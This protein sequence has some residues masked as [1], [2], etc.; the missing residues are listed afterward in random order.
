MNRSAIVCAVALLFACNSSEAPRSPLVKS[1]ARARRHLVHDAV[2]AAASTHAPS[3]ASDPLGVTA[4]AGRYTG[5]GVTIGVISDSFAHCTSGCTTVAADVAAGNLPGPGNPNGDTTPVVVVQEGT[6]A[7]DTAEGRAMLQIIYGLAPKAKLCFATIGGTQTSFANA[8][9][10]LAS[11]SGTCKANIIVDDIFFD[12]EPFFSDGTVGA[13]VNQAAA[14]GVTYVSSG[15]NLTPAL[16][17]GTFNPVSDTAARAGTFGNLKLSQVPPALTAG[18]F[19]D[20]STTNAQELSFTLTPNGSDAFINFQWDDPFVA[21]RISADYNLLVF[22]AAGNYRA[23]LSGIDKNTS[24]GEPLELVN[25]PLAGGPYQVAISLAAPATA[26][27]ARHLRLIDDDTGPTTAG[28]PAQVFSP[29]IFGHAA[30]A[31]SI[32]V[33]S[34]FHGDLTAPEDFNSYGPFT[35]LFDSAGNRLATAES[36][37]KPEVSGLDGLDT[38]FFPSG[39]GNDSDADGFPNL[40]GDTAS[41]STVAA[42]AALSIQAAGGTATPA[43]VASWL[44]RSASHAGLWAAPDG[45]GYINAVRATTLA[46][47]GNLGSNGTNISITSSPNPSFPGSAVTVTAH[48]GFGVATG[49][50]AAIPAVPTGVVTFFNGLTQVKSAALDSTGTAS[51]QFDLASDATI[52]ATYGGD[53]TNDAASAATPISQVVSSSAATPDAGTT[54]PDA[55]TVADG[56]TA[57]APPPAGKSGCNSN[58]STGP[59]WLMLACA[60]VAAARARRNVRGTS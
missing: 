39:A 33:S 27:T 49:L 30:A 12:D 43:Q 44:T 45:F 24:T 21:A 2:H 51:V 23:D 42:V 22:D 11:T 31:G 37:L 48:V 55:G 56:G 5:A 41:A 52:R 32:A 14:A 46:A 4:L 18:G 26:S 25:L 9:A 10:S 57:T 53:G 60:L 20:F 19:H 34:Y 50:S 17:D 40:F 7:G 29:S 13:A 54:V 8:I 58:G 47:G 36:R 35:N 15:G 3:Q 38:T 1:H 6:D 28:L 16:Y 59:L